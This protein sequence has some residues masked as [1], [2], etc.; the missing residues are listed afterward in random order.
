MPCLSLQ[1]LPTGSSRGKVAH[2]SILSGNFGRCRVNSQWQLTKCAMNAK[3]AHWAKTQNQITSEASPKKA[4]CLR[5][6]A[7]LIRGPRTKANHGYIV[8]INELLFPVAN[9]R[10]T[11]PDYVFVNKRRAQQAAQSA[12]LQGMR[13]AF[14]GWAKSDGK[15]LPELIHE[16]LSHRVSALDAAHSRKSMM[17]AWAAYLMGSS[18]FPDAKAVLLVHQDDR[19]GAR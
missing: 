18:D 16:Q 7:V 12:A 13:S 15:F 4:T 1:G 14:G 6:F 10:P 8:P 3:T 5:D 11:S 2:G 17:E 19:M 9:H